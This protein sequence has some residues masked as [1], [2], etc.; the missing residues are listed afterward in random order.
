MVGVPHAKV[1]SWEEERNDNIDSEM[2]DETGRMLA[3]GKEN[4]RVPSASRLHGPDRTVQGLENLD[5][6]PKTYVQMLTLLS[7]TVS[8]VKL[9][10]TVTVS[11]ASRPQSTPSL[12]L[13]LHISD[14]S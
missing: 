7:N 13:K 4:M 10:H 11:Q 6:C 14:I 12:L 9:P 2:K 5:S 3:D 8:E 1:A